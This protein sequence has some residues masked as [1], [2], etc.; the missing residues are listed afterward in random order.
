MSNAVAASND[1]RRQVHTEV[2]API[3]AVISRVVWFVF[4][5]IEIL[6]AVRFFLKLMGANAQAGFVQMI[7]A[8]S[9]VFMAPF[10]AIFNTQRVSG[11]TFE[12]SALVAIA[13]YALIAWG[14]VSL[15][16]AI[17]PRTHSETVER[18]ESDEDVSVK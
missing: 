10:N 3:E 9:D 2:R 15:I 14:I 7:H 6:I 8:V 18:V 5:V 4:A 13:V 11:A 17:S 16:A 1:H 12:W